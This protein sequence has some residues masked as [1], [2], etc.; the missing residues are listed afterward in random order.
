MLAVKKKLELLL[1]YSFDYQLQSA[2]RI[3]LIECKVRKRYKMVDQR[4]EMKERE[5]REKR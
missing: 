1:L 4:S 5:E 2:A 3:V